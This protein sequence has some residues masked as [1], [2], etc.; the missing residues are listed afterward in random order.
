MLRANLEFA[1]AGKP[2]K[3]LA[4]TSSNPSE[5]KSTVSANIAVVMAQAGLK[6][7][8][9]DADLRKPT[10]HKIFGISNDVGLTR[11]LT[12]SEECWH[13]SAT[14]VAV[15]N[16][17]LI[18]SGPVPPNPADL[19]SIEAFPVLLQAIIAESDIVILDTPPVLAVSDPLVIAR[20]TDAVL[21]VAKPGH[22]RRESLRHA[23]EALR[24]GNSRLIGV[25]LNQQRSRDGVGY[26]YYDGYGP[27]D[28]PEAG[29]PKK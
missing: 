1:A 26:Y 5:G 21:L 14:R 6:T 7:V 18:P 13:D 19:L 8:L 3:A 16:L 15:P 12:H 11:L 2:I 23:A 9:I 17:T 24:K 27:K 20:H 10:L 29:P 4:I 28:P 22:T 25:V